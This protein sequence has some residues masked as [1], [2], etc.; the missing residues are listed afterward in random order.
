MS[1]TQNDCGIKFFQLENL[2]DNRVSFL[3]FSLL[4]QKLDQYPTKI[5]H[6]MKHA[7]IISET[8]IEKQLKVHNKDTPVVLICEDGKRSQILAN[9]L[10]T[11]GFTNV[12][13]VEGGLSEL[14]K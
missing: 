1:V 3:F 8:E 4:K 7:L 10:Q 2:I 14:K 13:F 6:Y 9:Q 11:K 12:F 5:E